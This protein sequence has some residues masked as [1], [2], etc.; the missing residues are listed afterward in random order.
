MWAR[1]CATGLAANSSGVSQCS[2]FLGV[3]SKQTSRST[4]KVTKAG[5]RMAQPP[6]S[7]QRLATAR[8]TVSQDFSA[9][10]LPWVLGME[11]MAV[12]PFERSWVTSH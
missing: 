11:N 5:R 9:Q 10:P 12:T 2:A 7:R 8:R 4:K 1:M 3:R 6:T